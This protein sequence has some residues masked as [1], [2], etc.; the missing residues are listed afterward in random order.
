MLRRLLKDIGRATEDGGDAAAC[1]YALGSGAELRLS[2]LAFAR[3]PQVGVPIGVRLACRNTGRH[4]SPPARLLL[5][6]T[7]ADANPEVEV[8]R[9]PLMA[10][11]PLAPG[12]DTTLHAEIAAPINSSLDVRIGLLLE[13]PEGKP[14]APQGA[15]IGLRR[16]L[17]GGTAG[18]DFD[19]RDAY[20]KADL[21]RDWWSIVGPATREEYEAQGRAKLARLQQ[22][23]LRADARILDIGCGTGQLTEPLSAALS[24]GGAYVG[25]DI[26]EEAVAFCRRRFPQANFRFLRNE[27]TRLPLEGEVFDLIYL[28]SVFTHLGLGEIQGMLAEIHRLLATQGWVLAD[29]FVSPAVAL[30]DG[31]RSMMIIN[32][33]ALQA[34]FEAAGFTWQEAG[35]A[36]WN[37][38]C[39]RV[40]YRLSRR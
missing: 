10:I 33:P 40:A 3:E 35:A 31:N 19:Y 21:E 7:L 16:R 36:A 37:A 24:P 39:R 27:A 32:E 29:A 25:T 17:S 23:G 9:Q 13:T 26:A 12:D 14:W 38:H 6:W 4:P 11:P 1:R 20:A 18:V 34:A 5:R 22:L 2:L 28:A 15:C 8:A 30:Q